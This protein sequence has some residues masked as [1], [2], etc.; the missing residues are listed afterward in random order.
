MKMK[1]LVILLII[2]ISSM[3][4]NRVYGQTKSKSDTITIQTSAQCEMCKERIEKALSYESGVKSSNLNLDSKK[5]TV[6]F[7]PAKTTADKI[8]KAINAVGYD[9]D[10][11]KAVVEAYQK[12][13]PCCKKPDD[14]DH[15][16]H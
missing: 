4:I 8:R 14:P 15:V 11:T 3:Q 6:I 9:A 2:C 1:N 12:L 7:K 10:N 16:A 13:P 5:I